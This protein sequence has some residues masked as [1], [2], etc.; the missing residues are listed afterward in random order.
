MVL[1]THYVK[2]GN[3]LEQELL[4]H[5]IHPNKK[6]HFFSPAVPDRGPLRYSSHPPSHFLHDMRGIGLLASGLTK[7][8]SPP[9]KT[10]Q[11][12]KQQQ[13]LLLLIKIWSF[14]TKQ[15]QQTMQNYMFTRH[16]F[17][18]RYS[19]SMFALRCRG[20]CCV[21]FHRVTWVEREPLGRKTEA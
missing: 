8:P 14:N 12:N 6:I 3:N 15:Q 13:H 21:A 7:I 4:I 11:T 10:K 5:L 20:N 2:A 18:L 1:Q 16:L 19:I 9:K 17:F